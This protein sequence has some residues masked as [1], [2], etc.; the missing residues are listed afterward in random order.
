MSLGKLIAALKFLSTNAKDVL[1]L[2]SKITCG[3]LQDVDND[4]A[5]KSIKD[6]LAE[7]HLPG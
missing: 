5:W 7:K 2:N 4:T 1:P 3:Q 6:I